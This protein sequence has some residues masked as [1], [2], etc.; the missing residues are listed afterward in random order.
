M[1]SVIHTDM[2]KRRNTLKIFTST[3]TIILLAKSSERIKKTMKSLVHSI[4]DFIRDKL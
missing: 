2:D 4:T 1:Q 3:Q